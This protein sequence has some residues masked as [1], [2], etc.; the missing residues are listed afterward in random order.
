MFYMNRIC[1]RMKEYNKIT[2]Y[3]W[4]RV[5]FQIYAVFFKIIRDLH[6][7]VLRWQKSEVRMQLRLPELQGLPVQQ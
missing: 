1:R 6:Y 7:G 2:A 5:A 3:I 4:I